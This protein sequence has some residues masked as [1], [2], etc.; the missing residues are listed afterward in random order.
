[1]KKNE[2]LE[3]LERAKNCTD[4]ILTI[5]NTTDPSDP[6]IKG[7]EINDCND[8]LGY[9]LNKIA[10]FIDKFTGKGSTNQFMS[11]YLEFFNSES[12]TANFSLL[13]N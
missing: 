13:Q 2:L 8:K 12:L 9:V 6:I 10:E 11:S 5:I 1:M 7:K 4:N 3:S